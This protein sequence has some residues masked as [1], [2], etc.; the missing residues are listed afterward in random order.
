MELCCLYPVYILL[1][2]GVKNL[3]S[4]IRLSSVTYS[5]RAQKLLER[6]GIKAYIRKLSQD[7]RSGGCGYG[8]EVYGHLPT[9]LGQLSAS[10]IRVLEV[11]EEY[12]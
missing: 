3:K 11:V 7:R 2:C 12:P 8:L 4:V 1:L 6:Q 10:G 5:I 9:I